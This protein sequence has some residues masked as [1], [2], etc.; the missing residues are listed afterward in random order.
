MTRCCTWTSS[1]TSAPSLIF[2]G[3]VTTAV[4]CHADGFGQMYASSEMFT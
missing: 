3:Y 2:L 1:V 4:N